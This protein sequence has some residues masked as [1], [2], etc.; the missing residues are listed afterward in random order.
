M[1]ASPQLNIVHLRP[2]Q[3]RPRGNARSINPDRVNQLTKSISE[4][5]LN[6]PLV[7][8]LAVSEGIG[9]QPVY[10]LLAGNHRYAALEKLKAPT[11]PTIIVN[12]DELRAELIGI[13]ENLCREELSPAQK[14][15]AVLRRKH[16]YEQLHPEIAHGG[17]RKSSRQIGDLK[18]E[19]FTK[20]TAALAGH[21]ERSLQR[22]AERGEKIGPAALGQIVGTSLDK[23][24]ELDAL[25][26][27]C[28][29]EQ[30]TAI[31]RASAGEKVSVRSRLP[32]GVKVQSGIWRAKFVRL[33]DEAPT[34]EDCEWA[35]DQ[36]KRFGDRILPDIPLCLDRRTPKERSPSEAKLKSSTAPRATS[37]NT[38]TS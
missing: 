35:V 38:P 33:M 30:K 18:P 27:L 17:N 21:S 26:N 3:I 31:A 15:A 12:A 22:L 16:I 11:I 5:G 34:K 23:G 9:T 8:R 32:D 1:T 13:D 29:S 24:S 6:S 20:A 37:S 7:V 36:A 14:T 2:E 10:E 28:K 4:V 19:R 25:A